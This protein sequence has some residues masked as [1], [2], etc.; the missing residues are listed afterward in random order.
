MPDTSEFPLPAKPRISS[1]KFL[2]GCF[3]V[4][5]L[6][7]V[8]AVAIP[9]VLSTRQAK[10]RL[11]AVVKRV[12]ARGEP[13]TTVE[14]ND[15]YQ[16]AK[17]RPDMTKEI[18]AA[19]AI[20]ED[21]NLQPLAKSL[22]VVGQGPDPPPV[23]QP[24][25]Q[26]LEAE[27]YLALQQEAIKT[28]HEVARKD[29]TARFPVDFT[30]GIATLLPKTQS[31]RSGA[32]ALSLQFHVHLHRGEISQG[33]DCVLAQ[34]GLGR[35]LEQEP[36]LVSQ[37]VQL[38]IIGMAIDH[39]QTLVRQADVSNADLRRLQ[40][41][42]RK[43]NFQA[44][45]KQGLAG[46]R[47]IC[48]TACLNPQQLADIQEMP[49]KGLARNIAEHQPQRLFD[50]AKMLEMNLQIAEGADKSLFQ[51]RSEALAAD[52]DIRAL[53]SSPIGKLYY[54]MTL[55]LTPAYTSATNGFARVAASRDSADAALAAE[56]YRR[57]NGKWPAKLADLVPE[58]LPAVPV[59]PFTNQPLLM[60]GTPEGFKV[61]SVGQDGKD[62]GGILA[63]DMKAGTDVGFEMPVRN[64]KIP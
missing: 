36:T 58:F 56:L 15:F 16:P 52:D 64:Q 60:K 21:P 25:D 63:S 42:L 59:D 54:M 12:Q 62:D 34:I 8:A 45:L 31:I 19:L 14:L 46:E 50:A 3:A 48:Y 29:G 18:I 39:T 35:A 26:L 7:V 17:G 24:W 51:A 49:Q 30:P 10:L 5:L 1:G 11:A 61:Y 27:A 43:V 20:C 41:G 55:L 47:T 53:A 4:L 6:L 13:L 2:L 32:R 23:G 28:F 40:A 57:K 33:V 44:S 38:A 9:W 37:L 22:P